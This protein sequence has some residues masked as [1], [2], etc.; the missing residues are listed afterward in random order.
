MTK[1]IAPLLLALSIGTL[2]PAH[3][4]AQADKLK[5][6]AR[7]VTEQPYNEKRTPSQ[8]LP[9]SDRTVMVMIDHDDEKEVR[10]HRKSLPRFEL[11]DR[12]KF[13]QLRGQDPV[14]SVKAGDLFVDHLVGFRGDAVMLATRRDTVKGVTELY[15][16]KLDPNLT[17]THP[18]FVPLATFD[19]RTFGDG[20]V[21][22]SGSGHHDRWRSCVSP[23][24]GMLLVYSPLIKDPSGGAHRPMVVV[25]E[26]MTVRWSHRME[27]K[28]EQAVVAAQVDNAGTVHILERMSV[29]PED[30]RDTTRS[31]LRLLRIDGDG[32]TESRTG[33]TKGH[34][35][36]HAILKPAADGRVICAGIYGGLN[37][38]GEPVVGEFV[39]YIAPGG[40]G[41]EQVVQ[42]P[43][44]LNAQDAAYTKNGIRMVDV[45]PTPDGGLYLVR[46]YFLETDA[47]DAKTA[48]SG[49]RWI[50]GPVTVTR[51]DAA[52]AERWSQ[53][54][55]RVYYSFD[56]PLGNVLCTTY[57]DDLVL[58]LLDSDALA[59]KRKADDRKL[60]Y[61]DAKSVYSAYVH[62]TGDGDHRAKGM[63]NSSSGTRYI[64]GERLWELGPSDLILL[65]APKTS[66]RHAGLVRI[67]LGE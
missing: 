11:Y 38:K 36:K 5:I 21:I 66:S 54:F 19:T 17:K 49:Q 52:G 9:I 41:V 20:K 51:R 3:T 58:F 13:T 42:R 6:K 22:S 18:Y 10:S 59:A 34:W 35:I 46:E 31:A 56:R 7:P 8:V 29:R 15:W 33:L 62:F 57:K 26:H 65:G 1:S 28:E 40:E 47:V 43:F 67:E 37:A 39:G 50:H 2:A 45:L 44:E 60:S 14:A 30:K 32:V 48:M 24:G 27:V 63:L 23:D 64:M 53:T 61:L 25:G 12:T 55:R 4:H 16:Q